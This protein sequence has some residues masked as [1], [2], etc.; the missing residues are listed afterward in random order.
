ML[1]Q[2]A[3]DLTVNWEENGISVASSNSSWD[4]AHSAVAFFEKVCIYFPTL[5]AD[6]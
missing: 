6:K 1:F 4:Y 3:S 2:W 5:H